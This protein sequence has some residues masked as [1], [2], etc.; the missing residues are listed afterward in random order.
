M[1]SRYPASQLH[2]AT[3]SPVGNRFPWRIPAGQSDE[4]VLMLRPDGEGQVGAILPDQGIEV[5]Y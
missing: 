3:V 1:E 2:G 4:F 5:T